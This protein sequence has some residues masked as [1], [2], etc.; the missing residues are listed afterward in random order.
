MLKALL[1]AG[2]RPAVY[3][4]ARLPWYLLPSEP[5]PVRPVLYPFDL[6]DPVRSAA[7][8]LPTATVYFDHRPPEQCA[9]LVV[10]SGFGAACLLPASAHSSALLPSPPQA[11]VCRT[12]QALEPREPPPLARQRQGRHPHAAAGGQQQRWRQQPQHAAGRPAGGRGAAHCARAPVHS[13]PPAFPPPPLP[14]TCE[15]GPCAGNWRAGLRFQLVCLGPPSRLQQRE[16]SSLAR[17]PRICKPRGGRRAQPPARRAPLA[18]RTLL[19]GYPRPC[20]TRPAPSA[21]AP[22]AWGA[23][24]PAGPSHARLRARPHPF[25]ARPRPAP[26]RHV[27]RPAGRGHRRRGGHPGAQAGAGPGLG[28]RPGVWAVPLALR[29]RGQGAG[30]PAAAGAGAGARLG[31]ARAAGHRLTRGGAAAAANGS[32]PLPHPSPRAAAA[33][34]PPP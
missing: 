19:G 14:T 6:Y 21:P 32:R 27:A 33:P 20:R 30:A 1:A 16:G 4:D 22:L 28:A 31:A 34:R 8:G 17:A 10:G 9:G 11:A 18:P 24:P 26:P 25:A 7:L 23:A 29:A 15:T 2:F 12:R 5:N 3:R 13:R